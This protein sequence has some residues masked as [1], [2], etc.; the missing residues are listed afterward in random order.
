MTHDARCIFPVASARATRAR[1]LATTIELPNAR[2]YTETCAAIGSV[3]W[4][5]RMLAAHR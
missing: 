2:A 3:M 4:N 1:R 5:A